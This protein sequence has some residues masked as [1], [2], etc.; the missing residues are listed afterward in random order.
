MCEGLDL[1]LKGAK[2][3]EYFLFMF[4]STILLTHDLYGFKRFT[5][6]F[7]KEVPSV[8]PRTPC[9]LQLGN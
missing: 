3:L 9:L 6:T 4:H 8:K 1:S 5:S 7:Q 2:T